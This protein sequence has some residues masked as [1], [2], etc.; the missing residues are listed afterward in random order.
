[1]F[2]KGIGRGQDLR[3]DHWIPLSDLMTGLMMIFLL[4]AVSY[5]SSVELTNYRIRQIAVRYDEVHNSLYRDLQR[6]FQKDLP[7][8]GAELHRD[9][10]IRF[11]EPDVLFDTG[12][13]VLKPRFRSILEDFFPRY[14]AI[15]S[16]KKYRKSISEIRIEGHT[17]SFWNKD[18]TGSSD[19]AYFNNMA[20]S[21]ARTR[22]TLAYVLGLPAV[23]REKA[24]LK[25]ELTANGLS[26]SHL[27]FGR[28][29]LEDS[30]ASQRVEFR[31]RTDAASR[32]ARIIEVSR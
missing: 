9:L 4:V 25:A 15:L 27:I 6:E 24:W 7:R 16:S 30:A 13:D 20:L 21:Q 28:K 19:Q 5:M 14:I 29:G 2:R 23:S 26:S 18:I 10:S 32:I 8:W 11:R 31:V 12:S 3:E 17:S 1:M 22:S